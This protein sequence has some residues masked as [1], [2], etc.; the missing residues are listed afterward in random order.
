[1]VV[2]ETT[3]HL[4]FSLF[5]EGTVRPQTDSIA[6]VFIESRRNYYRSMAALQFREKFEYY[7]EQFDGDVDTLPDGERQ[8][9]C[10][11]KRATKEM[12]LCHKQLSKK[13][14]KAEKLKF[15]DKFRIHV[16]EL[17]T[18]FYEWLR[19]NNPTVCKAA[20]VIKKLRLL[21]LSSQL[22]LTT[23]NPKYTL[24]LHYFDIQEALEMVNNFLLHQTNKHVKYT[25]VTGK[26]NHS[27]NGK[28]RL[29]E[30]VTNL[31]KDKYSSSIR[32]EEQ[33]NEGRIVIS[34]IN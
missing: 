26:G 2:V 12:F 14:A 18:T 34:F 11:L 31:L 27:P 19:S 33:K 29:K 22:N 5:T 10:G 1:M 23:D 7:L 15:E 21:L 13:L 25:L 9:Y 28:P 32:I 17:R 3:L 4:L 30:A 24:D 16:Q 20:T 8:M 6:I